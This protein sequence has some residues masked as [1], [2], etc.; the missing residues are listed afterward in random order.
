MLREREPTLFELLND[1]IIHLVMQADGVSRNDILNLYDS[2]SD[3]TETEDVMPAFMCSRAL[4][5][6]CRTLS[7]R[8]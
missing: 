4:E 1:P 7:Q 5:E 6:C 3:R 2:A 8:A